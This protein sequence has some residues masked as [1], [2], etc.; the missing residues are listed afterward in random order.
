LTRILTGHPATG[1]PDVAQAVFACS[2]ARTNLYGTLLGR[3]KVTKLVCSTGLG[4]KLFAGT[5]IN[6]EAEKTILKFCSADAAQFASTPQ[7]C[8]QSKCGR[9]QRIAAGEL[10]LYRA[11]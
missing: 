9:P 3:L 2:V 4:P 8:H 7:D 6:Y 11:F 5:S 1:D 10:G